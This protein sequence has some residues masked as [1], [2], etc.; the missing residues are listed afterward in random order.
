VAVGSRVFFVRQRPFQNSQLWV[1][2]GTE[3]GTRFLFEAQTITTLGGAD[4]LHFFAAN[5]G[6]NGVE[7][8]RSDGTP[9]GTFMVDD[10][11]PGVGN[12]VQTNF[13]TAELQGEFY[14]TANT[15]SG[16]ELWKSDGLTAESVFDP[17]SGF[18]SI[19]AATGQSLFFESASSLWKT[20]GGT[21]EEVTDRVRPTTFI[22]FGNRQVVGNSLFFAGSTSEHGSELWKTDGSDAGTQLVRDINPG[23]A[24]S[25]PNWFTNAN[26]TLFFTADDG[27]HGTEVWQSD[28][29]TVGTLLV[30]DV[31]PNDS[32]SAPH[33]LTAVGDVVY[34]GANA[35]TGGEF[36]DE[37]W[38]AT[39]NPLPPP[40]VP[41]V[42]VITHGFLADGSGDSLLPLAN[43]I[44]GK[45][46]R[47]RSGG[48][49]MDYDI[50]QTG[51][52]GSFDQSCA[53]VLGQQEIIVLWDWG[54]ESREISSGWGEAAADALVA[55]LIDQGLLDPANP[56]S[57]HPFHFIGHS[58]GAAVASDAVERL[59]AFGVEV[60][61]VT[62]LDPH[63]F[64]QD[65]GG[66]DTNQRLYDLGR[67][68]ATDIGLEE[69]S[70]YGATV[71]NNVKFADAYYQTRG[72]NGSEV[73]A[74]LVPLG[75]PIPGAYNVFL[76]GGDE[77][78]NVSPNP[79]DDFDFSGDHSYVWTHYYIGS[80]NGVAPTGLSAP[81]GDVDFNKTGYAFSRVAANSPRPD[82]ILEF[83]PFEVGTIGEARDF[84]HSAVRGATGDLL[85][86]FT[87]DK[88]APLWDPLD[89]V[90]GDFE[91]NPGLTAPLSEIAP[92]WSHH[93][94]GGMADIGTPTFSNH[95]ATQTNPNNSCL[96][97]GSDGDNTRRTH[98]RFY[99]PSHASH[100][101]FDLRITGEATRDNLVIKLGDTVLEARA[102]HTLTETFIPQLV[103]I[104]A[105]FK[106]R[107][108]TLT[109]MVE[110]GGQGTAG[111]TVSIDNVRM[112]SDTDGID[113]DIDLAPLT[114]SDFFVDAP[115]S[116]RV[117]HGGFELNV[118][119]LAG[120]LGV[121]VTLGAGGGAAAEIESCNDSEGPESVRLD[122]T[123]EIVHIT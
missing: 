48:C 23:S 28:G 77:L 94:G 82:P 121:Q 101:A 46:S 108:T 93:G 79:Y 26:G 45:A 62:Y 43:A 38:R 117:D 24:G 111:D 9:T 30:D 95:C 53:S 84:S 32:F 15:G 120:P 4:G 103:E 39:A 27:T 44:L 100:L 17:A 16:G 69:G 119:D 42:T 67:P 74:R 19:L 97:L 6:S 3:A 80:V 57:N 86:A 14:F 21:A 71:W 70:N 59:A 35:A 98:N 50:D 2:D 25:N 54:V 90:N 89:I 78:P 8:Y 116:G 29:S 91:N 88:Y 18:P 76:N 87:N 20:D 10:I 73:P 1:S 31:I 106:N 11:N 36:D 96:R 115:T 13:V 83:P 49:L 58:F 102:I 85:D 52:Q 61:H 63:D 66:V 107:I 47:D 12:G 64:N 51:G 105:A 68:N 122:T 110:A 34:F 109:F 118:R 7:L 5:N 113:R 40:A 41:G 60:D 114:F 81:E 37:L 33:D 104:P 72:I 92:G 99:I 22:S 75:R 56:A 123:G 112:V 55:S 65:L